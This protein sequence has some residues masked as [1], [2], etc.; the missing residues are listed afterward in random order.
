[1]TIR[2][3]IVF[4][5]ILFVFIAL[6]AF[7]I[8]KDYAIKKFFE[9]FQPPP[10]TI[11]TVKA[12]QMDWH[13]S[14]DAV[15][16]INA[17]YGVDVNSEASGNVREI[18][19]QSGQNVKKNQPLI[20]IDDSVEQAQ[21]KFNLAE[22]DLKKL[23]FDRQDKL[24]RKGAA[25]SSN[26][27]EA[28]ANLDQAQA[29]V[30]KIRAQIQQKHITAPFTGK[31]GIRLINLGQYISPGQTAIVTLQSLDP[32][33][34]EFYLP[35]QQLN[36]I[37][38]G[39]PIRFHVSEYPDLLFVGKI[40]AINS[41]VDIR[42]HNIRVQATIPNCPTNALKNPLKSPMVSAKKE[43]GSDRVIVNCQSQ[44]N[45]QQ[46]VSNFSFIPGMFASIEVVQPVI[47]NQIVLPAT[48]IA[49]SL[50]GD[51]VYVIKQR[52]SKQKDG[53]PELYV[54]QT[55]VRTGEQQ[56]NHIVITHG[57]KPGDEVVSSG[58]LKLQNGSRV[59]INNSVKMPDVKDIDKLGE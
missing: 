45:E 32:L 53:E 11:S 5:L 18:H 31:L 46:N 21:L 27:D 29:N 23:S 1:M 16:N 54:Q 52:P 47:P 13:P 55:F 48:A 42:T 10:A 6:V 39:Q 26:V 19:F 33:F 41:K 28:R 35:E 3:K 34:L 56:G 7:N 38:V 12:K 17:Q 20:T 30:E 43:P 37:R 8:I 14:L 58:Q 36:K 49:Y 50:Y 4:G 2:G 22:L 9:G 57:L 40:S 24:F 59:K 44:K 25:P 51:S 15:G